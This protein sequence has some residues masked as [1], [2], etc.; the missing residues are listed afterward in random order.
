VTLEIEDDGVGFDAAHRAGG[1]L[2]LIG[3]GERVRE[4]GGAM[5]LTSAVGRGTRLNV[6]IPVDGKE[7]L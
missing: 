5:R 1:G 4:L 7:E 3:I 2:G 6:N